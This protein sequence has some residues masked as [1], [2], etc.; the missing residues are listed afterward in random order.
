MTIN[1]RGALSLLGTGLALTLPAGAGAA[2]GAVH[3]DH[4][5]ASGDPSA[6]GAILWTRATPPAGA[7]ADIPLRWHVAPAEGA[8][9]IASGEVA[10][11]AA[12]DFTAKVAASGLS[13]GT[14]YWFWFTSEDGTRSPA[15]RFRTLPTGATTELVF[16]VVSCQLYPG[17]LY[18]AYDA[19]ARSDRL[20]AVLHL[21]DYIY[22]YGAE[23]YGAEMGARLGRLP[24]PRHEILTLAD[25][26]LRH[27]QVKR[28]PDMQAAHARAAFICVWDDHEV[29][30]DSW[31]HGAENH[32]A[33]TEG[34]WEK[35]KA[36]A[37][38]AYFEWMPIRDPRPGQPW[39]AINRS[40][41]FGDLAT[42]AMVETRLLARARQVAAKGAAPTQADYAPMMAERARADRELL[43]PRQQRWLEGTLAASVKAGKPW[44]V[45]GNQVVMARVAG[46]DVERQLGAERH[47]AMM[48][49]MPAAYRERMAAALASY[50]AGLPFNFDSW[51]GYPAA[52]ERLYASFRRAGSR[53]IVLSGDSHAA[54]AN[55]LHDQKGTLAAVE[56]GTTAIS[57]PSYG[58]LL[59]G[60]GRLIADTNEEVQFCDQ[61]NKGFLRLT[62]TR[63]AAVAEF[64]TVSTIVA[65]PYTTAVAA[66]F[67]ATSSGPLQRLA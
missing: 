16:A 2:P 39:D 43:G 40:F 8:P 30:N 44:Q 37:M 24:E 34:D 42:L 21:G 49:K 66:R 45:L 31:M 56:F 20:D 64:A 58:S 17:G 60:I 7:T 36:A 47:A 48:A 62:L 5:V 25:Y 55:D 32:D 35:R 46:P 65:K 4:G 59:P 11:R 29:A 15:G 63:E 51:D 50:R 3:F 52:R 1:R 57:S 14:E 61:D 6:D 28:D 26:R 54:W 67:R 33:A 38:Q 13:A 27:A 23:G 10:A 9:P 18:N 53:P 41:E 12:R 19:I 22:E